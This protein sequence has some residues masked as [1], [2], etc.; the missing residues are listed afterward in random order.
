MRHFV[1]DEGLKTDDR[2]N[3]SVS[4]LQF[5]ISAKIKQLKLRFDFFGKFI[6]FVFKTRP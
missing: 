1:E 6:Y 2:K 3:N 5:S 4:Y